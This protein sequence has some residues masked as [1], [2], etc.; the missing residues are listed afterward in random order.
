MLLQ[1]TKFVCLFVSVESC[2]CEREGEAEVY[3]E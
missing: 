2:D 3:V 1:I